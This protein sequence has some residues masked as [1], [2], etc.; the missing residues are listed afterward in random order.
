MN[1]LPGFIYFSAGIKK[2]IKSIGQNS[3]EYVAKIIKVMKE[4]DDSKYLF[5]IIQLDD[6]YWGE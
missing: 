4:R 3:L 2:V 6:V 1:L 5:G